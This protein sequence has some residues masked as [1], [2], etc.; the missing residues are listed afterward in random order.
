ML[1]S[2]ANAQFGEFVNLTTTNLPIQGQRDTQLPVLTT[3]GEFAGSLYDGYPRQGIAAR[4]SI[5]AEVSY[6]RQIETGGRGLVRQ[7]KGSRNWT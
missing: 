4:I 3:F 2:P 7:A 6:R 5:A 1:I